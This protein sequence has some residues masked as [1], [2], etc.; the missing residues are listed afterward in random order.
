MSKPFWSARYV[1]SRSGL[2]EKLTRGRAYFIGDEQIILV[3]YGNG[4]IAYGSRTGAQGAPGEP[5]PQLQDQIDE[6]A[7]A[8]IDT[9]VS[10]ARTNQKLRDA[11]AAH[12]NIQ[13]IITDNR[14]HL[15]S[16][17]NDVS[18]GIL[19]LVSFM[20]DKFSKIDN[21]ISI[22]VK[23][24]ASL[25]PNADI[26][27]NPP[28]S[29]NVS[30]LAKDELFTT[31]TGTYKVRNSYI[32]SDGGIIVV[33]DALTSQQEQLISLLSDGDIFTADGFTWKVSKNTVTDS[34][35]AIYL[36]RS[37]GKRVIETLKPGD[38]VSF[39]QQTFKVES[40]S[41]EDGYGT[42]RL[43]VSE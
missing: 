2:P 17:L 25:Y 29:S 9:T 16:Q 43:T 22:V 23:L 31:D 37:G 3:D 40:V 28:E 42:I 26:D 4:P 21:V 5:I 1:P 24:L 32:D 38:A 12:E 27:M 7:E 6:L 8:S 10:L 15:T 11:I 13:Q 30:T 41:V 18:D 33:L 19:S 14:E 20:N 35:G 36:T 39:D 34:G